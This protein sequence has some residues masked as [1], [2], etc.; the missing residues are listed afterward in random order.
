MA[1]IFI[2]LAYYLYCAKAIKILV[3]DIIVLGTSLETA[4]ALP[5]NMIDN[6]IALCDEIIERIKANDINESIEPYKDCLFWLEMHCNTLDYYRK[7]MFDEAE[8]MSYLAER[9][10]PS[11]LTDDMIRHNKCHL[12]KI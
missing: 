10:K 5:A 9:Y 4:I 2:A 7:D 1:P 11:F 6:Q 3:M 12:A 8:E